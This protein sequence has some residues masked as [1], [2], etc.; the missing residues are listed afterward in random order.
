MVK[1]EIELA[2]QDVL[3]G[4][5]IDGISISAKK[6]RPRQ[7]RKEGN[8]DISLTKNGFQSHLM[9]IR[10]YLGL[11]VYYRPWVE[12][13]GI[14]YTLKFGDE[15]FKYINSEL[16]HNLISRFSNNIGPGGKIY[17]GYEGDLETTYEL[18]YNYPPVITRLGY[19]LFNNGFTWYKDWYFPEGGSEG[20]QKLQGEKP[21]DESAKQ[22]HLESIQSEIR[23]FIKQ[24]N[25][26]KLEIKGNSENYL[27]DAL[28]RAKLVLSEN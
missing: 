19:E 18:T 15:S 1:D 24:V 22:R 28:K 23:A 20:G 10:I 25:N 13:F 17:I 4:F 16:E 6:L 3:N 14:D 7:F 27:N 5:E 9:F 2:M 21:L 26:E 8:I 11:G 12:F